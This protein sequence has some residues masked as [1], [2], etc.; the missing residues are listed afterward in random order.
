MRTVNKEK[1]P[2]KSH[3]AKDIYS[4]I[5]NI[6]RELKEVIQNIVFD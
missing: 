6:N 5:G 2:D 3:K 1:D 4:K